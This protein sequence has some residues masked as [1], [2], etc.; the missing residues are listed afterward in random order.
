M[1][2]IKLDLTACDRVDV[3]T[4]LLG[5]LYFPRIGPDDKAREL[6]IRA[7]R[8][9]ILRA[10]ARS[11]IQWA[12][13]PQWIVPNIAVMSDVDFKKGIRSSIRRERDRRIA[14][15]MAIGLLAKTMNDEVPIL[16]KSLKGF[17]LV[18]LAEFYIRETGENDPINIVKRAWGPS[19]PVIHLAAALEI[20]WRRADDAGVPGFYAD[21]PH[22]NG[23][24]EFVVE[25]AREHEEAVLAN[26]A[27][28]V[29]A[30]QML[31]FRLA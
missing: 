4:T 11:D 22:V 30:D 7:N 20:Y 15:M 21:M 9:A 3:G 16:P 1:P 10:K 6:H 8:Q 25:R 12:S 13:T 23:A 18:D 14:G 26:K 5:Y 29:K 2:T 28:G 17:S 31:R 19:K 27:F 24:L